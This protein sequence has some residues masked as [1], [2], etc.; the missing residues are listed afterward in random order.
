MEVV[1]HLPD[2]H[3]PFEVVP[4]HE[5]L[6]VKRERDMKPSEKGRDSHENQRERK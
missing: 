4:A 3:A 1:S 5:H 6:P 2:R